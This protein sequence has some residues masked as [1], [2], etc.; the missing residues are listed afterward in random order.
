MDDLRRAGR[1]E[2]PFDDDRFVNQI[3]A[4][5]TIIS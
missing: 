2:K 5:S 3:P 1:G 4:K